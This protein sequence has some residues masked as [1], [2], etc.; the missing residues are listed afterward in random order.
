[1]IKV[2]K[3]SSLFQVLINFFLVH[4]RC[5]KHLHNTLF[6]RSSIGRSINIRIRPKRYK[7]ITHQI[8]SYRIFSLI[9]MMQKVLKMEST[10]SKRGRKAYKSFE[11]VILNFNCFFVYF[12]L[13]DKYLTRSL[14]K[15]TGFTCCLL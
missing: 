8:V 12:C 1:M 4:F 6:I 11:D 9:N 14:V 7:I 10:Y 3:Q 13:R 15:I 2:F 5:S